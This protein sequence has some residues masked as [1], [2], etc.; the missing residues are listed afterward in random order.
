MTPQELHK[1]LRHQTARLSASDHLALLDFTDHDRRSGEAKSYALNK[2]LIRGDKPE[3]NHAA[4]HDAV[5]RN[6]K[7]TGM[8]YS[9]YSGT[10]L[11]AADHYHPGTVATN[12]HHTSTTHDMTMAIEHGEKRRTANAGDTIHVNHYQIKP[13]HKVLYLGGVSKHPAEYET[14]VPAGT[15]V[16]YT[17]TTYHT[18]QHGTP[19]DMHHFELHE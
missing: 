12:K 13:H 5:V 16:R 9:V 2:T 15:K 18:D 7:P 19:L 1:Q 8:E 11:N 4:M 10:R 17:H 6:A 14:V 3:G